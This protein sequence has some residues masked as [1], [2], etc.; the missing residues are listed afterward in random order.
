M[1]ND[2][3]RLNIDI[4]RDNVALILSWQRALFLESWFSKFELGN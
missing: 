4:S 3:I 2:N 1:N